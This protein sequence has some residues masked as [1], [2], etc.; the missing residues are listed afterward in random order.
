MSFLIKGTLTDSEGNLLSGYTVKA[1]DENAWFAFQDDDIG[2]AVTQDDGTFRIPFTKDAFK[3]PG[4][5]DEEEPQV[6]LEIYNEAETFVGK[7][8]KLTQPSS[9]DKKGEDKF[10][11]VVIGSGFGGT[12]LSMSLVNKFADEDKNK[13][14]TDKR[15]VCILERGQWWVSHEI[16]VSPGRYSVHSKTKKRLGIREYLEKYDVPYHFW[17]FPNNVNG[18]A[19][20]FNIIRTVNRRGL[21]DFRPSNR[22]HVV[23]ASGVGGGSLVYANVTEEPDP[24]VVDFWNSKYGLDIDYTNLKPFFETAKAFIGVNKITTTTGNG[25][26][27][28]ARTKVFQDAAEKIR[29]ANPSIVMNKE[30]NPA[31]DNIEDIYA[32]NLSITDLPPQKDVPTIF[33]EA[34]SD[35]KTA[36]N[37]IKND[38]KLQV[39]L[40]EFM[41]KYAVETNICERRGRCV[42]GCVPDARHTNDKKIFDAMSDEAKKNCLEVRALCQVNDIEPRDD[43]YKYRLYY[44]DYSIRDVSEDSF[45]LNGSNSKE[46]KL[47]TKFFKWGENGKERAVDAK[48]VIIAAGSVG[49]TELLLKSTNT[50]KRARSKNLQLSEMLGKRFSTNGDL[51]GVI[52]PTKM[53]TEEVSRAPTVTSAI[54]FRESNDIIYTI[55]DSGLP[56][57]FAGISSIVSNAD[58]MKKMMALISM[59]YVQDLM[60]MLNQ[61]SP[62][63]IPNPNLPLAVSEQDLAHLMLLSGMGTDSGDGQIKLKHSW[64]ANQMHSVDIEF[65]LEKQKNLFSKMA[66][67]MEHLAEHIGKGGAKSLSIPFWDPGDAQRSSTVVLHPLGGCIM[68]KDNTEGVVNS[69]GELYDCSNAGNKTETYKGI[70]VVDGAIVPTSL[71]VNSSLTI[72]A[73]AF[74]IAQNLVGD[75][76]LPVEIVEIDG[77][78]HYLPK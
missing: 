30:I 11:A 36:F 18:L 42:L 54:R 16:P 20:L 5:L 33:K 61:N 74:R 34:G 68:G 10:E 47:T 2:S 43:D 44:T 69:L 72:S 3:K 29:L 35:F 21:Y 49:S 63:P 52:Q 25:T 1:F 64:D 57:M 50:D 38:A 53:N 15:K 77:E 19:E 22:V 45:N 41:R 75:K 62:I 71:G 60:R 39:K 24:V 12:I 70:Y 76:H 26:F 23:S 31:S 56:S 37:N 67:S 51:L 7:T 58:L 8:E 55:E 65:D 66:S 14:D 73:L 9:N 46:Y 27:K 78:K 40:A 59:G 4:E 28:L 6:Y 17:A 32:V 13:K 48:I